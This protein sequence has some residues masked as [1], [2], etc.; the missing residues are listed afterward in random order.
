MNSELDA[1]GE[2][3]LHRAVIR[4]Q[5]QLRKRDYFNPLVI[6]KTCHAFSKE[7]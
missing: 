3:N 1:C 7:I 5:E 4:A 6:L 2:T